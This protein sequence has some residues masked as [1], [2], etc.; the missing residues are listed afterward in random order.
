MGNTISTGISVNESSKGTTSSSLIEYIDMIATNYILKQNMIDMIRFTDKEYYDNMLIL[1]SFI[2]KNQLTSLDIGILKNRVLEGSMQNE[3]IYVTNTNELKEISLKNE[4]MKQKALFVISKFYVKIMTLFS[5][6]VA[7][8]DPQYMYED[9]DGNKK[10]FQ[11]KDF[12]SYKKID[13]STNEL[14]ISRVDNPIG[15][16]KKRLA[17]LQ[18]KLNNN[19]S[20]SESIVINPGEKMCSPLEEENG[21]KLDKE[22][23][24]KE[25]DALYF[26]VYDTDTNNWNKRSEEMQRKYDEDVLKFYQI[27]TGKKDKPEYIKTFAEIETLELHKVKRCINR[28]YYQDLVVSKKDELFKK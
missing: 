1:T 4:K 7:T 28:D 8:I 17:I 15:L 3:N 5:A 9:D 12:N 11:L 22:I 23:G 13:K 6:I 21:N 19:N 16:V 10:F 26:D 14:R 2:M 18:N 27:F 24:I 25:L 20:N